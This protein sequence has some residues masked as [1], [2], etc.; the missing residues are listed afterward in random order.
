MSQV[1][2]AIH[3]HHQAI[4]NTLTD[5]VAAITVGLG[6]ADPAGLVAFLEGELL[7]HAAGEERFLYPALDPLLRVHGRPTA[8]MRVDHE[9]I[10]AYILRIKQTVE[11]LEDAPLAARADQQRELQRLCYQ[12]EALVQLHL[13]KE[14]RIFMP[15]FERALPES[16][17][18]RIL[19]A[20]HETPETTLVHGA[21]S[22]IDPG[23]III[24][25]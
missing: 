16:Q 1:S 18:Q 21:D 7:P 22:E 9:F 3:N 13:E 17:Q 5:H 8:T 11:E 20:M 12:L 4:L 19:E 24:I 6:E 10:E 25:R 23:Q 2:S 14:E 15:L